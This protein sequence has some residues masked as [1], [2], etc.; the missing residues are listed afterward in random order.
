MKCP[1]CS[2]DMQVLNFDNEIILH[3]STCGSSFF[4]KDGIHSVSKASALQLSEEAQ[5]HYVLG[6]QKA[7]PKDGAILVQK[8][9]DPTISKNT[10]LL[11]CPSCKGIFA[12][13]DDLLKYKGVKE[14][15]PI[16]ATSLK[17]LPAPKTIFMLSLV[18]VLSLAF[19]AGSGLQNFSK[20]SK[21]D[22]T[23]KKVIA[24]ADDQKH[25]LFF[26]FTTETAV[27]SRVRFID[28]TNGSEISKIVSTTPVKIH[29]LVISDLD[30]THDISYQI[31]LNDGKPT[32][33]KKLI[34]K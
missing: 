20:S 6:N 17:L 16:S 19:V 11:E 12:Y 3:C 4:E 32:D 5:G 8:T 7:C 21:A 23:I 14:P 26:D 9:D 18:A 27:T 22:E 25:Y 29:H 13:P 34:F 24:V 15:S 1:N 31:T 30:L 33:E 28:S 2:S 10:I